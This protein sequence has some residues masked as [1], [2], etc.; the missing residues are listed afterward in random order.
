MVWSF[1]RRCCAPIPQRGVIAVMVLTGLALQYIHRL[2]FNLAITVIAFKNEVHKNRSDEICTPPEVTEGQ[3]QEELKAEFHWDVHDQANLLGAFFVGYCISQIPGGILGDV[4]GPKKVL[5]YGVLLSGLCSL[6]TPISARI[7]VDALLAVRIL[8]GIAQGPVFPALSS[9]NAR[10]ALPHERSFLSA[11][12][13]S[14]VVVG[15]VTSNAVTGLL[16]DGLDQWDHVFYIYAVVTILWFGIWYMLAHDSVDSHPFITDAEKTKIGDALK[17]D[18]DV[19]N[20]K[21]PYCAIATS[22]PVWA[23][24]VANVGHDWAFYITVILLPQYLSYVL[25]FDV[26]AN[27]FLNTLP[28]IAMMTVSLS[29]S[30]L[31]DFIVKKGYMTRTIQNKVYL[32]WSNIIPCVCL[33]LAS[34]AGCNRVLAVAM[35]VVGFGLMG[36]IYSSVRVCNVDMAPNFAGTLMAMMNGFGSLSGLLSPQLFAFFITDH[37]V[38][39]WRM[40]FFYSTAFVTATTIFFYIFGTSKLQP[41]NSPPKTE[42]AA[43]AVE[44]GEGGE[45]KLI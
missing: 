28:Y 39:S 22:I 43:V 37:T 33:I 8:M 40:G 7:H 13:S 35:F 4:F 38:A 14:G 11:F 18:L 44:E 3:L 15:A 26:K 45:D 16:L 24:T 32:F 30:R 9:F 19:T 1:L 5:G 31:A 23:M 21:V 36:T 42:D 41:W 25:H 20:V 12:M 29:S 17:V 27:G 10:W 6:L 2:S 34:Y